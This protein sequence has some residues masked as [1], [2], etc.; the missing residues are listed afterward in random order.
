M[1][2]KFLYVIATL[3]VLV[4]AGLNFEFAGRLPTEP[5]PLS[6]RLSPV[7][8]GAWVWLEEAVGHFCEGCHEVASVPGWGEFVRNRDLAYG[9]SECV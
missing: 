1:A 4:I 6:A 5:H 9:G 7:Q 2:R 8:H 3:V